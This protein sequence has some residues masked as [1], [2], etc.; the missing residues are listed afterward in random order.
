MKVFLAGNPNAGKTTLFNLLTRAHAK[1]G[2]WHGVTVGALQR[3][4]AFG[5]GTAEYVDLPGM[6]TAEGGSM[7]EKAARAALDKDGGA[8]MLFVAECASLARVLPLFYELGRGRRAALVLT[9]KRHFLARGGRVDERA[10]SRRLRVPVFCAEG[11]GRREAA[12]HAARILT[13]APLSGD[14]PQL[15]Q[16]CYVPAREGLT[17]TERLLL[18]GGVCVPLFLLFLPHCQIQIPRTCV[19]KNSQQ[20]KQSALISYDIKAHM[21]HGSTLLPGKKSKQP[22]RSRPYNGGLT[23][24]GVTPGLK[25][26]ERTFTDQFRGTLSACGAP[27]FRGIES[28][29]SFPARHFFSNFFCIISVFPLFCKRFSSIFYPAFAKNIPPRPF[30]Q[31]I[32]LKNYVKI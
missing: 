30:K 14:A 23:P 16:A 22:S 5:G 31:L 1:V 27:L 15:V 10:L 4:G 12:E 21:R 28:G 20:K 26:Q 13:A 17:R 18:H 6:Y 25:T 24:R 3:R 11:M 7:E 2:N 8:G 29:Y 9:K 32:F 19:G